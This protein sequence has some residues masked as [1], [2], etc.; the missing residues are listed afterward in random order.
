MAMPPKNPKPPAKSKSTTRT[1]RS[2]D[3]SAG[4]AAAKK[5]TAKARSTGQTKSSAMDAVSRR[6]QPE[7]KLYTQKGKNPNGKSKDKTVLL[8]KINDKVTGRDKPKARGESITSKLLRTGPS[9]K[10]K[11]NAKNG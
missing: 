2:A 10:A 8:S 6:Y 5:A 7:S 3:A 9:N 1:G 11:K 4:A